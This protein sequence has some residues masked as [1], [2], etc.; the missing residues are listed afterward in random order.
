MTTSRPYRQSMK[1]SIRNEN[2]RPVAPLRLGEG[3][4]FG[5]ASDCVERL[6][7]Y[8]KSVI[9]SYEAAI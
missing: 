9:G 1:G 7:G 2:K 8:Q 3:T 5:E 4:T 6:Q